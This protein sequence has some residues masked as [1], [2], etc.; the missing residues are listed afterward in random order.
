MPFLRLTGADDMC[1][2]TRGAFSSILSGTAY[3]ACKVVAPANP[4][5][6]LPTLIVAPARPATRV[7]SVFFRE[8]VQADRTSVQSQMRRLLLPQPERKP[9]QALTLGL[10]QTLYPNL[11]PGFCSYPV[12][13]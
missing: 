8:L 3:V 12:Y 13:K 1:I 11:F 5:I 9:V 2:N 10:L 4:A 7:I 6:R